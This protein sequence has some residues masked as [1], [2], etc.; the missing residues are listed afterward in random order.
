MTEDEFWRIV[1]DVAAQSKASSDTFAARV[2]LLEERL[3]GLDPQSVEAFAMHF[4]RLQMAAYRWDLWGAAY[5]LGA[6]CSDDGFGDFRTWLISMGRQRFERALVD[7]DSLVE[8]EFGDFAEQDSFFEE[9]AY[10]ASRVFEELTDDEL[11]Y[12]EGH[13]IAGERWKPEQLPTMFPRLW[14]A[15]E[16]SRVRSE[17]GS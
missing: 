16:R 13:E 17:V 3:L 10:V 11:P 12:F 7:P 2:A 8:V 9:Y 15:N 14:K 5:V 1:D 4:S 6:G